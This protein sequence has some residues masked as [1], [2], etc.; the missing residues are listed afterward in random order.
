MS[1][2]ILA[3]LAAWLLAAPAH[4]SVVISTTRVIYPGQ[5]PEVTVQVLNRDPSPALLQVWVDDGDAGADPQTLDVPFVVSPAMFRVEADKGQALR[6]MYT[7]TPLPAD[8]E[9]LYWLNMLQIP[10]R[11]EPGSNQL[12]MAIRTR[13][14][15]MFRPQ[16]LP[17]N[18]SAAPAAVRWVVVH[19]QGQWLLAA[20]NPGPFFVNLGAVNLH[21]AGATLDAGAGY[22][23]PFGEQR[24][25]VQGQPTRGASAEVRFTA[26][27]DFGAAR[28]G[29]ASVTLP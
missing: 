5:Q 3:L 21:V 7:G 22:V 16:G 9:S 14:K 29:Q 13:I 12:Q 1:K 8:R 11:A 2:H 23:P 26:L 4:A 25:R 19:E 24:F 27:D 10:P 6:V 20:S 18:A 17:G 28:P 15:L